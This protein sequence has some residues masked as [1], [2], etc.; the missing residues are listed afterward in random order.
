MTVKV[1]AVFER[2]VFKPVRPC[3]LKDGQRVSLVVETD[4]MDFTNPELAAWQTVYE[5]LS[6]ED[7]EEIESI[8]LGRSSFF[9]KSETA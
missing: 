2:G 7:V 6:D 4:N 5:G 8:A 9:S 1:D 3:E